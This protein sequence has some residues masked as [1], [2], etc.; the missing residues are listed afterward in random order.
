VNERRDH[1]ECGA[2]EVRVVGEVDHAANNEAHQ[3]DAPVV[4]G[5]VGA[6][7]ELEHPAHQGEPQLKG[8]LH[9]K[10]RFFPSIKS[11][12]RICDIFGTGPDPGP[13]IRTGDLRILLFSSVT[14]KTE[15]KNKFFEFFCLLRYFLKIHLH[16]FVKGKK[17]KRRHKTVGIRFFLLFLL[18]ARRIR[19]RM[20]MGLLNLH[21]DP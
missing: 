20:F 16:H 12:L 5:L 11:V 10:K 3:E 8:V 9:D 1:V 21:P 2:V 19:I 17:L 14:S 18:D 13:R 6:G 7:D 4:D 15:T